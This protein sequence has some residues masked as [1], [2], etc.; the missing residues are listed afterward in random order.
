MCDN[1]VVWVGVYGTLKRGGPLCSM[2]HV[3]YSREGEH[4][5]GKL[6]DLGHY[7]GIKLGGSSLIEVEIQLIP[8]EYF[9]WMIMAEGSYFKETSVITEEGTPIR[10]FE[11]LGDVKQ[12]NEINEW[13]N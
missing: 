2:E 8:E 13:R 12:F 6:Y 11:F 7:P 9:N 4:I 1:K 3:L 5:K 10:V